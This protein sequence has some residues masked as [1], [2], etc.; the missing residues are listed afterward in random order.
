MKFEITSFKP[1]SFIP[2]EFAYA[3][4]A[5]EGHIQL[6]QNRNPHVR[7]SALPEG[8]QSLVL[9]MH[10][11]DVPSLGDNVNRE[12]KV[13]RTDLPRVD[14]YH[15]VLVNIPPSLTEIPAGAASDGV[16]KRGKPPG[17][18]PFGVQGHN[19][20]TA[21]FAGDPENEGD[22]GGYDGPCP[23]WNDE[24]LHHYHFTLYALDVPSVE[25]PE[26]FRGPDVVKA[27]AGH[28]LAQ[29]EQVGV[30]S[31]NPAVVVEYT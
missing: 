22:H 16:T 24:R 18:T 2:D 3:V 23:P 9:L 14:F 1:E 21:W 31:L 5:K 12:G 27:M 25:L 30:Y 7:W 17:E 11:P 19:D 13:V 6:A 15:W 20:Y 28:I 8:T 10:D 4:P 29:A 26:H